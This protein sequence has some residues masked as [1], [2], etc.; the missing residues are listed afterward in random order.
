[1]RTLQ[2][3][4]RWPWFIGACLA[5]LAATA[6]FELCMGRLPL[7]PDGK[8]GWWEGDI[9]SSENSQRVADP[10]SFSHLTHGILF[11]GFLWLVARKLPVRE[12]FFIA[13]LI[14]ASW[15]M[16]EN[17]PIIINRYRAATIALGYS[18]DSILNSLSDILFM[19]LGFLFA[20]KVRPWMSITAV[21]LME[22]GCAILVRDNLTLNVIMLIHPI[23]A[24]KQ[25]QMA[26]HPMP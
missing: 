5:V 7:G 25:W 23:E 17:S 11:Y 1:M 8:F 20:A 3:L 10:Y 22:A 12:R 21:V 16:L 2:N 4:N 19:S 6:T 9:W 14:E 24:I 26:G 13:L 18:G 15:E